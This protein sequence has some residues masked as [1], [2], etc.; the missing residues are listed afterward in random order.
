MPATLTAR[1]LLSTPKVTGKVRIDR[2]RTRARVLVADDSS[3]GRKMISGIL[4]CLG[5]ETAVAEN[6]RVACNL[7]M[8]AWKSGEA[9]DLI[10]MDMQM[11]EIDGYEATA[12]LRS[13]GYSG[14]IVA[15][16]ASCAFHGTHD[17]CLD[18][19]CDAYA[20]K[21]ITFGMLQDVVRRN[22]PQAEVF[23][24]GRAG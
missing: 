1:R 21:P 5:L 4:R 11:P 15:L 22:L 16:T 6:G 3:D 13:M 18:A 9:F 8:S 19:G 7:A 10:L 17:K 20:C 2:T 14:R 24:K 23:L 12:L